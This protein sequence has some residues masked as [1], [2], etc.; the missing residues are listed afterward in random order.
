MIAPRHTYRVVG[1][2]AGLLVAGLLATELRTL[3]LGLIV[4]VILALPLAAAADRAERLGLPRAVGATLALVLLAAVLTGLGFAL[5]PSFLSEV[6]QFA[7][8]LPAILAGAKRGLGALKGVHVGGL[9]AQ[10]SGLIHGYERHPQRLIGPLSQ[11]GGTAL[12]AAGALI[13]ILVTAF[14]LAVN[15]RPVLDFAL[16]MVPLEERPRARAVLERVR[17]AWLGWMTAIG[18]DMLVLG[19]L[20]WLGMVIVGLPFAVGFATFSAL[21]TVI[22]NYGSIISAVPPVLAGLSQSSSEAGLVLLVYIIV[23]QIEGNLVLPL[24]MARTVD[25]HPAVVAIGVLMMASL[26]GLV[27]VFIAIPLLSLLII[28]VQ[29]FWIEPQEKAAGI[30]PDTTRW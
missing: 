23:N 6:R 8:R 26:F 16:R 13:L 18:L 12:V 7:D 25:M 20:L 28:V 14:T 11:I 19:G 21:M 1:L 3:L 27:G 5:I 10:V 29:A 2:A 30:V 22:P 9:S 4:A 17:V 15:P 24:I